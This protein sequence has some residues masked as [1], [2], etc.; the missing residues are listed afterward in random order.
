MPS[1]AHALDPDEAADILHQLLEAQKLVA[2]EAAESNRLKGEELALER[3]K[4]TNRSRE[5]DLEAQRIAIE[6]ET[7]NRRNANINEVI[8][9]LVRES[10]RSEQLTSKLVT[11][12]DS[13]GETI[14]RI[15]V[16]L[17][18]VI[19]ALTDVEKANYA[20]LTK[21]VDDLQDSKTVTPGN[22]RK[23]RIQELLLQY[24]G[25]LHTLRLQLAGH[26]SLDAPPRLI[27]EIERIEA[28]IA[29][30]E[31]GL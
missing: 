23:L 31:K 18:E 26:G 17:R 21:N 10:E 9:R 2:V 11:I 22:L 5:L 14:Q 29:E 28:Q 7:E 15:I 8:Q 12:D 25:T 19:G 30:L 16:A 20:L 13:F 3:D 24:T 4:V 6:R 1:K 27:N